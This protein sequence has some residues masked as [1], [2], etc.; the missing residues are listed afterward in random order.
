MSDLWSHGEEVTC[1]HPGWPVLR[2]WGAVAASWL[3]L[4]GNGAALQFIVTDEVGR[5]VGDVGWVTL[6]EDLLGADPGA[7]VAAINVFE[8][9]HGRWLM[10]AHHGS[11]IVARP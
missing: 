6:D 8:R 5:V 10:V 4:F 7:A 9:R 2:G 11:S 3:A 1:V